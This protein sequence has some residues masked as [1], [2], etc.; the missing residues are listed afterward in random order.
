MIGQAKVGLVLVPADET[1]NSA[2][3]VLGYRWRGPDRR[4]VAAFAA[5]H[6]APP[7]APMELLDSEL[8]VVEP[9]QRISDRLLRMP[10][11]ADHEPKIP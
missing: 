2:G 4:V 7:V 5:Y 11:F 8:I 6:A 3:V 1:V 10:P 9:T